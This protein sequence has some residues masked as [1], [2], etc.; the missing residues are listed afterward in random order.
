MDLY[1]FRWKENLIVSSMKRDS[2]FRLDINWDEK[3]V[4]SNEEIE[5]GCR[6]RD[7]EINKLGNIYLLCDNLDF[8][9]LSISEYDYK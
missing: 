4:S 8:I 9:E 3:K 7:M 2:L 6:I 5:I 1:F